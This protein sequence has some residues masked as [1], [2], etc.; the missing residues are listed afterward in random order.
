MAFREQRPTGII[1]GLVL[2]LKSDICFQLHPK[3]EQVSLLCKWETRIHCIHIL[4]PFL[5]LPV[6]LKLQKLYVCKRVTIKLTSWIIVQKQYLSLIVAEL[7]LQCQ[8]CQEHGILCV[9]AHPLLQDILPQLKV[10]LVFCHGVPGF[11]RSSRSRRDVSL[12]YSK[13]SIIK[14]C[15]VTIIVF[16]FKIFF[17]AFCLYW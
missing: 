9:A 3:F 7:G 8:R 5:W 12:V 4:S 1:P 14:Y 2:L 6:R 16:F 10:V 11:S 13:H 17:G 15:H